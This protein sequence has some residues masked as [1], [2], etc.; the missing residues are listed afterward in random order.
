M[1]GGDRKLFRRDEKEDVIIEAEDF[2]IGFITG[3]NVVNG[4]FVFEIKLVAIKSGSG[5]IVEDGLIRD[6]DV[7]DR[8]HN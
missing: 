4:T 7:E 2:D 1:I 6:V 8:T 5:S 3:R